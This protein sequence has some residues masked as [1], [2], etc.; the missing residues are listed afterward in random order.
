MQAPRSGL[1]AARARLRL[2]EEPAEGTRG[3]EAR[4]TGPGG[5][6]GVITA[7]R[8]GGRVAPPRPPVIFPSVKLR[9]L[10]CPQM[11][12]VVH[13]YVCMLYVLTSRFMITG[14]SN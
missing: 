9:V 11:S 10:T 3:K 12:F 13:V 14:L 1:D 4:W 7:P 8:L 6:G 5:G 2:R